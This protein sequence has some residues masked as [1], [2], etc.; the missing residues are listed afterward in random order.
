MTSPDLT[1]I[2]AL[3]GVLL[4]TEVVRPHL[5][6]GFAGD[7]FFY[8]GIVLI[9]YA[10]IYPLVGSLFGHAYPRMALSTLFPCP[11]QFCLT[12]S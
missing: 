4:L 9:G 12:D 6:F 3:Q 1:A 2:F 8:G 5:A 10:L 7:A 11:F